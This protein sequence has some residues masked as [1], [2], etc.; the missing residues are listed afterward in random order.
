MP[1]CVV[2]GAG[3]KD[4]GVDDVIEAGAGGVSVVLVVG[5]GVDGDAAPGAA[6]DS[7]P[8]RLTTRRTANCGAEA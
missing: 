7:A 6:S 8:R 5:D 3:K 4:A 1:G 2:V